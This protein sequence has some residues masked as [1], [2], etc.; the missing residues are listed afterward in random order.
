MPRI[1]GS[2]GGEELHQVD[3]A[4]AQP[5]S[6]D[7]DG[8]CE[9]A[10]IGRVRVSTEFHEVGELAGREGTDQLV[11]VQGAGSVDRVGSKGVVQ[12]DALLRAMNATAAGQAGDR[13]LNIEKGVGGDTDPSLWSDTHAPEATASPKAC[14]REP[15]SWSNIS[16]SRRSPQK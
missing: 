2:G 13:R 15:C 10:R 4:P 14:Q 7:L 12:A 6:L 16:P 11:P 9:G 1:G 8:V 5:G 3:S